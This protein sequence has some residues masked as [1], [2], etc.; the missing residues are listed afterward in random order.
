MQKT[1]S[2]CTGVRGGR[3]VPEGES[4][5]ARRVADKTS[6]PKAK[7]DLNVSTVEF[8]LIDPKHE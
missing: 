3:V 7:V 1:D 5:A 8:N 6:I 4:S 2:E